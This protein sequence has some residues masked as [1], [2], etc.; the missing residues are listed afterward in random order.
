[1][2]RDYWRF[3]EAETRYRNLFQ[4]S[5]EAV[6]IVD[7]SD[8]EGAGSQPGGRSLAGGPALRMVGAPLAS[9]FEAPRPNRCR[10]WWPRPVR[11]ANEHLCGC[12]LARARAR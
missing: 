8:A 6:L 3:R 1:M 10:R 9:L 12:M 11:W 4:T 5:P 7:G 2:E